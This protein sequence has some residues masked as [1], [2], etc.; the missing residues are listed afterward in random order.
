MQAGALVLVPTKRLL[1]DLSRR[2][3]SDCFDEGATVC[4]LPTI[5]GFDSW[6]SLLW[7]DWGDERALLNASA[8]RAL[9]ERAI[10]RDPVST[11]AYQARSLART[12]AAAWKIRCSWGEA[13]V[14]PNATAEVRAFRRW[15]TA[16]REDLEAQGFV[17]QAQLPG[18]LLSV[19]DR[20]VGLP[21]N[22]VLLGF[23]I[24]EPDRVAL[25]QRFVAE[26]VAVEAC[27]GTLEQAGTVEVFAAA[28]ADDE[29]RQA[30]REVAEALHAQP[31]LKIGVVLSDLA[32]DRVAVERIFAEELDP[33]AVLVEGAARPGVIDVAGG[34]ALTDQASVSR[35]LDL[36]SLAR[37]GNSFEHC[38]RLLLSPYP[39]APNEEA[40]PDF[41]AQAEARA[42]LEVD[43]RSRHLRSISL[44]QLASRARLVGANAFAQQIA[45]FDKS[46][47]VS[48]VET[49]SSPAEPAPQ[50][51]SVADELRH[52]RTLA[53]WSSQFARDL[54]LLGAY[55]V[56]PDEKERLGLRS[57][58]EVLDEASRLSAYLRSDSAQGDS[59]AV[60]SREEA[61][62]RVR[63][64]AADTR[65]TP[66]AVGAQVF[67][68]ELLDATG[69]QFDRL[70]VLGM[71]DHLVPSPAS[72]NPLLAV[73]WQR[74]RGVRRGSPEAE[75]AFARERMRRLYASA[76]ALRLSYRNSG[77]SGEELGPSA[78]LPGSAQRRARPRPWYEREDA[79]ALEQ[80]PADQASAPEIRE[81]RV[82]SLQHIAACS[83]RGVARIRWAAEPLEVPEAE[84]CAR[85]RGVLVHDVMEKVFRAFGGAKQLAAASSKQVEEVAEKAARASLAKSDGAHPVPVWLHG[86]LVSW[87]KAMAVAWTDYEREGREEGWSV[88]APELSIEGTVADDL[89]LVGRIDRLDRLADGG[90]FVVDY[91]TSNKP[92]GQGEWKSQRPS[93]PQLPAYA[94]LLDSGGAKLK[95]GFVSDEDRVGGLAFANLAARDNCKLDGLSRVRVAKDVASPGE[96][97]TKG[98]APD[99]EEA[100][101]DMLASVAR[102]AET[103]TSGK[104]EVDPSNPGV[105]RFC[106]MQSLCRVFE[107]D[108]VDDEDLAP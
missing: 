88:V 100:L 86:P 63:D 59:E 35:A 107:A 64:L 31:S 36:L 33:E 90:L 5:E 7:K 71:N 106:G 55:D 16:F 37:E 20:A 82:T 61:L 10:V 27:D 104:V 53:Q 94:A 12:A 9:W 60:M 42:A 14:L 65:T 2:Y 80:R 72:P 4:E 25:L 43:L 30:A 6:L 23:E 75:L 38:S 89:D 67:I 69:L 46:L 17:T 32:S 19:L 52:R 68:L 105:C 18:A 41:E 39:K 50:A 81:L 103:W 91:K 85:T 48:P 87:A 93:D 24:L 47:E 21:R 78:L 57:L 8:E 108:P 96:R 98:W 1:R 99:W 76:P 79:G 3:Q 66:R 28:D 40:Q 15:A 49:G 54:D 45:N 77:A 44:A 29:I 70:W 58:H 83:F 74:E 97:K 34:L 22:I 95:P 102:T 11:E 51:N 101:Q 26:G 73:G 13:E 84:P 92:K 56:G 62:S